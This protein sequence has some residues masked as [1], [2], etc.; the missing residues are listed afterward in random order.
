MVDEVIPTL[1]VVH[2][3]PSGIEILR[4]EDIGQTWPVAK[5]DHIYDS[6]SR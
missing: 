4:V 3:L 1:K 6:L 5:V 2:V